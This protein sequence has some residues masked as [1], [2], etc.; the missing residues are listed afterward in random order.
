MPRLVSGNTDAPTMMI[1]ERAARFILG[2]E[3]PLSPMRQVGGSRGTPCNT[4]QHLNECCNFRWTKTSGG[5]DDM[6]AA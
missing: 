5:I 1:G 2:K 4:R 6:N 3:L